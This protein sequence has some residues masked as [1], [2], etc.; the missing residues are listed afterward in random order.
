MVDRIK[1]ILLEPKAEWERIDGEVT[2]TRALFT[3]WAVPLA[4]IGPVAGLIGSLAF[5]VSFLGITYRPSAITAV[6]TAVI[7]YVVALLGIWLLAKIIDVLAPSFGAQKNAVQATKVAVYSATASWL[8]GIFQIIPSLSFLGILGLYSLY[9]L[10]LGLPVL[11]KAPV[12]KAVTYFVAVLVAAVVVFLVVG[13]VTATIA[14]KVAGPISGLSSAGTT[15]GNLNVPGVGSV[16]LAKMEAASKQIEETVNKHAD[17]KLPPVAAGDLQNLLPGSVAGWT[18]TEVESNSGSVGGIGGSNAQGRYT[19][20]EKSMTLSVTDMG[21]IGALSAL[22]GALN[23]ESN[24]QTESG[25][26]KTAT[27][28]GRMVTEEW[29]TSSNSGKYETTVANRFLVSADGQAAKID[30]LKAAVA[31]IDLAKL[32]ALAK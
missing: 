10:Y 8:A 7:G 11:M 24:K 4:A 1:R 32:S 27:V 20:G 12:D 18:R 31:S 19:S 29:D 2:T 28:E 25:Y 3:G 6:S 14:S 5:G 22:G 26:K 30:D 16:D 23:I 15:S 21:A 17:G 9:L 13:A